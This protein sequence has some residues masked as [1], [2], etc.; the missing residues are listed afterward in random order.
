MTQDI[1]GTFNG[2]DGSALGP[3]AGWLEPISCDSCTLQGD[4]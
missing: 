1:H 4:S 2:V 3:S